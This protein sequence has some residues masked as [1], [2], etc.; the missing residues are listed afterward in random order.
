MGEWGKEEKRQQGWM[1]GGEYYEG[2]R[3]GKVGWIGKWVEGE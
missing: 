3:R 1:N 2:E